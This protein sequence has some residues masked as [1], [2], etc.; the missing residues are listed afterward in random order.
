MK[1]PDKLKTILGICQF[2]LIM[3]CSNH[4][5]NSSA[6]LERT[7]ILINRELDTVWVK[8]PNSPSH[9]RPKF[10]TIRDTTFIKIAGNDTISRIFK[11]GIPKTFDDYADAQT[12][13]YGGDYNIEVVGEDRT[14]ADSAV[15][16]QKYELVGNAKK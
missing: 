15:L 4:Q 10:V 5:D 16:S 12:Y 11:K 13:L 1:V 7:D 2:L 3:G 14:W 8:D 9:L 6:I